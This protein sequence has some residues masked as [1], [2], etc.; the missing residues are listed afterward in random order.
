VSVELHEAAHVA[1]CIWLRRPV[2]YVWRTP[3]LALP[4]EEIGH[5]RAPVSRTDGIQARDIA[6]SLV[7]Y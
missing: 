6:V 3:G 2:E 5:C 7:G 1:A 4:G